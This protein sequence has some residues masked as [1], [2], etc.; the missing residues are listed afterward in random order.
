MQ[1]IKNMLK[2]MKRLD[3]LITDYAEG[4]EDWLIDP[5]TELQE[6]LQETIEIIKTEIKGIAYTQHID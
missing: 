5:L 6:K 1:E 4:S 2:L 3:E